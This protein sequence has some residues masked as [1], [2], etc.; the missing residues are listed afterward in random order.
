M[1]QQLSQYTKVAYVRAINAGTT[2]SELSHLTGIS[3][4][5]LYQWVEVFSDKRLHTKTR[6]YEVRKMA[7]L[8]PEL[9]LEAIARRS[10]MSRSQVWKLLN[11]LKLSTKA[12]GMEYKNSLDPDM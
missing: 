7:V 1:R 11:D 6:V 12:K 9:S 2:V 4:T 10:K 3:R 8:N 5:S